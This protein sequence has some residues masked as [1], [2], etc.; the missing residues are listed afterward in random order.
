MRSPGTRAEPDVPHGR[1]LHLDR[2][3]VAVRD[4]VHDLVAL[5]AHGLQPGFHAALELL[6][7]AGRAGR[8]ELIR[9]FVLDRIW[10]VVA[11]VGSIARLERAQERLGE[12]EVRRSRNIQPRL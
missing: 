6:Y 5:V 2:D 10:S 11:Q 8:D 3:L 9:E 7:P 12:L 4:E 1:P